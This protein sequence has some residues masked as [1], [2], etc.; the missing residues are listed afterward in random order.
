MNACGGHKHDD[1][2][3]EDIY[4]HVPLASFDLLSCVEAL[5]AAHLGRLDALTIDDSKRRFFG[6]TRLGSYARVKDIVDP[7]ERPIVTPLIVVVFDYAPRR[8]VVRHETPLT[9]RPLLI[10]HRVDDFAPLVLHIL[11]PLLGR[12]NQVLEL[13]PVRIGEIGR[14]RGSRHSP[15]TCR[16]TRSWAKFLLNTLS[17]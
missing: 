8:K 12:G 11:R 7:F 9:A 15:A 3:A 4:H 16:N 13:L 10:Q 5:R 17:G 14:I 6:A 1:E 2:Q